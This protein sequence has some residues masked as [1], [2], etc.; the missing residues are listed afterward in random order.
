MKTAAASAAS[1]GVR[2]IVQ[3]RAD[4]NFECAFVL[5]G[6]N[7]SGVRPRSYATCT[8]YVHARAKGF[9]VM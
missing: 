6:V 9:C 7:T 1:V 8:K 5:F 4:N 2:S 3:R